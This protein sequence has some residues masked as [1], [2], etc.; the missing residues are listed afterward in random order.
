M[1]FVT[2]T[3]RVA[4]AAGLLRAAG[5]AVAQDKPVE[6]RFAHWLPASHPL[7]KLGFE[8]W[9]KSV[10]AASKGSI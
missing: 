3:A 7:A 9:A 10:E 5:A 4:V 6:L 2:R 8:P 1:T